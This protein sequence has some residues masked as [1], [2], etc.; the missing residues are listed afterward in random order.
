LSDLDGWVELNRAVK[1]FRDEVAKLLPVPSVQD[2]AVLKENADLKNASTEVISWLTDGKVEARVKG[3][4][5]PCGYW[6]TP[7]A[8]GSLIRGVVQ[9]G[10]V[11]GIAMVPMG[12]VDLVDRAAPIAAA[13]RRCPAAG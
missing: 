13:S 10:A 3:R 6:Q 12:I 11:T 4:P 2:D 7:M 9:I 1:E 5:V 8:P